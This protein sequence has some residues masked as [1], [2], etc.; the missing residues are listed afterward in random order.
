MLCREKEME[1]LKMHVEVMT[2]KIQ[3]E[4][5]KVDELEL[6]VKLFDF[7]ELKFQEQVRTLSLDP[8][9]YNNTI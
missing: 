3:R 5:E 6:K 2:Y 9:S 8:E 4:Q 7:G 1:E